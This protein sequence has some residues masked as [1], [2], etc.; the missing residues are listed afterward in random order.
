MELLTVR[1]TAALLRVSPITVRR[2]IASGRLAAVRVG[3]GVRVERMSLKQLVSPVVPTAAP[4]EFA[5]TPFTFD[6]PLWD[7]V[8]VIEDDGPTDVSTNADRY[9]ADAYAES[10]D[11]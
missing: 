8:G 7:L 4:A 9:L 5:G 6:D 10:H 3:R 11:G 2:Y 1:E